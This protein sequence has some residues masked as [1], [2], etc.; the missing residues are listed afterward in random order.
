MKTI[1]I[2]VASDGTSQITTQGFTGRACQEASRFLEEALGQTTSEILTTEFH[3][4]QLQNHVTQE[5]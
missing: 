4:T 1:E 2:V 5:E 3:Q